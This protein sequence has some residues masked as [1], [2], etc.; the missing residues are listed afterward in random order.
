MNLKAKAHIPGLF[1]YEPGR[2]MEEVARAHG[3]A[4]GELVKLA[5]NENALGPSPRAIAAMQQ[6]SGKMHRYPDGGAFYLRTAVAEQLGVDP[7]HLVFGAGSNEIIELWQE[8]APG[9]RLDQPRFRQPLPGQWDPVTGEVSMAPTGKHA[10]V[11][12]KARAMFRK[13]ADEAGV[14]VG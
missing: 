14:K 9:V 8:H 3:L 12:L 6:A 13:A 2:P 5:S 1:V 11:G 10:P 4:P 7:D